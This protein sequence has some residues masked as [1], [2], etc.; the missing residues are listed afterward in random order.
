MDEFKKR[1]DVLKTQIM[2]GRLDKLLKKAADELIYN[3]LG[4]KSE[5]W[6]MMTKDLA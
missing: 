3:I 4:I 5:L 1:I 2:S 6:E